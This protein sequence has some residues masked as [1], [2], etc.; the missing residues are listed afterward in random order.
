MGESGLFGRG[1]V[2]LR[3]RRLMAVDAGLLAKTNLE[4]CGRPRSTAL[5]ARGG[6]EHPL[7]RDER[8]LTEWNA[9]LCRRKDLSKRARWR[10]SSSR[11]RE[12]GFPDISAPA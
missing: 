10:L 6:D 11:G 7:R 3:A 8:A 12:G 5:Y 1:I 4:A 2:H 9:C